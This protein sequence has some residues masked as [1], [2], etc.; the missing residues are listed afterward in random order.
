MYSTPA[1]RRRSEA[2]SIPGQRLRFK[3]SMAPCI[4]ESGSWI[5]YDENVNVVP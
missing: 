4:I 3:F 1:L 2:F 5:I